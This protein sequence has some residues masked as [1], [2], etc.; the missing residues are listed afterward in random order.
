[1]KGV[2]WSGGI[3]IELEEYFISRLLAVLGREGAIYSAGENT[4][5]PS[6]HAKIHTRTHLS[7]ILCSLASVGM[8]SMGMYCRYKHS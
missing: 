7:R 1:M 2:H 4:V 5:H 3:Y 6:S 8:V